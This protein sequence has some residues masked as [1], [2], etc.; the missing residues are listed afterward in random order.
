MPEIKKNIDFKGRREKLAVIET[1]GKQYLI[2]PGRKLKIEKINKPKQGNT[3]V[4]DKVLLLLKDN[5]VKIGA[6]Y[7]K[8]AGIKAKYLGEEK[9]KKI[10]ILR[11]KSKTRRKRKKGHRQVYSEVVILDF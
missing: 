2:E 6:P 3:I 4:F 11:Y 8:G 5:D 7:V 1:G 9:G 10:T